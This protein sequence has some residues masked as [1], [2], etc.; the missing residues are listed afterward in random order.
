MKE[1]REDA[2]V[3]G[4]K[5]TIIPLHESIGILMSTTA[6]LPAINGAAIMAANA[7]IST[8]ADFSTP[9]KISLRGIANMMNS[10]ERQMLNK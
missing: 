5:G 7:K 3:R 9:K 4:T 10:A 8:H 2:L 1:R 6:V